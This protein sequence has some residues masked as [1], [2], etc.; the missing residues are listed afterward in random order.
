MTTH[1]LDRKNTQKTDGSRDRGKGK[2]FSR[3]TKGKGGIV[4]YNLNKKAAPFLGRR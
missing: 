3:L 1:G 4:R 2:Y